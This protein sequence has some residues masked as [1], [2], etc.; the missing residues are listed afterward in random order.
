MYRKGESNV[1]VNPTGHCKT[2]KTI[3]RT[4]KRS[5]IEHTF[6]QGACGRSRRARE[7]DDDKRLGFHSKLRN[8]VRKSDER[9]VAMDVR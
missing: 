1:Q 8:S 7:E 5:Q 6:A 9:E 4:R 3:R 2:G